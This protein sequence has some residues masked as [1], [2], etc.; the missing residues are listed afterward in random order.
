MVWRPDQLACRSEEFAVTSSAVVRSATT[1]ARAIETLRN[2]DAVC[3]D[4]DSTVILDE[5]IDELADFCGAGRAVAE[6]T[7][8]AMTGTVPFEV[9]LAARLSLI[10]PSLSQVEECLK[11]RPPSTAPS[12]SSPSAP[13]LR[14]VFPNRRCPCAAYINEPDGGLQT[15]LF[16]RVSL[17]HLSLVFLLKTSL[18][19]NCYLALPGSM[20]DLIP[21]GPLRAVWV[22]KSSAANKTGSFLQD[23]CYDW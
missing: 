23:S 5:G 21:Q 10:K 9:A 11:R 14:H 13:H 19:A 20:L 15:L 4:V 7:A 3:F 17:W 1:S 8:K 18:Q 2:A 16:C 6:W 12:S 22:K